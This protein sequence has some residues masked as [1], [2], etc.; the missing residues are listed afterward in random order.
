[1]LPDTRRPARDHPNEEH[2]RA[3]KDRVILR[4]QNFCYL[5]GKHADYVVQ[6]EVHH[7]TYE[8][9]GRE[10]DD[11]GILLCRDPCHSEVTRVQRLRIARKE[12]A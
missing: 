2:L 3:W 12:K 11:D 1:M 8:R 5:C 6:M 7:T 10:H 9:F 4:D